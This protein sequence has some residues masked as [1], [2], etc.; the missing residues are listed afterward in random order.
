MTDKEIISIVKSI[1]KE[2]KEKKLSPHHVLI[3][4]LK[5]R[6]REQIENYKENVLIGRLRTLARSGQ[7]HYGKTVNSIWFSTEK[8][9]IK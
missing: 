1:M 8:N 3:I 5:Q 4:E 7:L 9:N 6:A 2:K